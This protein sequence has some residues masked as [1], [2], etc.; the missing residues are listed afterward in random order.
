MIYITCLLFVCS[1]FFW[2]QEKTKPPRRSTQKPTQPLPAVNS[3]THRPGAL[4]GEDLRNAMVLWPLVLCFF[5]TAAAAP[6]AQAQ[7]FRR[8]CREHDWQ[9]AFGKCHEESWVFGGEWGAWGDQQLEVFFLLPSL[10]LT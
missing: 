1:K 4:S 6:V 8:Q 7:R 2:H 9:F 10:K 5:G 3:S